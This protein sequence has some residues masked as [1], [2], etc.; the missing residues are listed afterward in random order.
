MLLEKCVIR[1]L[2]PGSSDPHLPDGGA[3]ASC[4]ACRRGEAVLRDRTGAEF[5]VLRCAGHR[6]QVFNSLPVSMTDRTDV[7]TRNGILNRHFLFTVE[8]PTVVD[9][10]IASARTGTPVGAEVR[11]I[12]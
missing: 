12:R 7:L 6:N 2:Y 8:A 1:E 5:P 4:A 10:V 9:R 3:G 11:R